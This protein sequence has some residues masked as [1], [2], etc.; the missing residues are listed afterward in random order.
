MHYVIYISSLITA[1]RHFRQAVLAWALTYLNIVEIVLQWNSTNAAIKKRCNR[2]ELTC[3][4]MKGW[5]KKKKEKWLLHLISSLSKLRWHLQ[6]SIRGKTRG[7]GGRAG[8]ELKISAEVQSNR[9]AIPHLHLS[10]AITRRKWGWL[11]WEGACWF[12]CPVL[13]PMSAWPLSN[14]THQREHHHPAAAMLE[15][16]A[17][18][19]WRIFRDLLVK[20]RVIWTHRGEKK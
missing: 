9:R 20:P 8:K 14:F 3:L 10:E 2:D 4:S 13:I 15:R 16:V 12:V 6:V 1:S 19:I 11:W 7:E 5:G 17:A 18:G